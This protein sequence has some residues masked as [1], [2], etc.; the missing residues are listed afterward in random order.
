MQDGSI[1][2]KALTNLLE[3]IILPTESQFWEDPL[4]ALPSCTQALQNPVGFP[5]PNLTALPQNCSALPGPKHTPAAPS[6][7]G[8]L[9]PCYTH[10]TGVA[11]QAGDQRRA[12]ILQPELGLLFPPCKILQGEGSAGSSLHTQHSTQGF[13]PL[14]NT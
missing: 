12:Q 3:E 2:W 10:T 7:T 4:V 5:L 13:S 14:S 6:T 9:T 11:A 8:I 1:A